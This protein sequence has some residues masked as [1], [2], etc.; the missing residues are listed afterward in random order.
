MSDTILTPEEFAEKLKI[1]LAADPVEAR[2]GQIMGELDARYTALHGA[3][4]KLNEVVVLCQAAAMAIALPACGK[5]GLTA[6]TA[7]P[8]WVTAAVQET[9]RLDINIRRL[10]AFVSGDYQQ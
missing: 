2:I 7:D 3:D 10:L 8:A 9:R 6:R 5:E 4:V 1:R